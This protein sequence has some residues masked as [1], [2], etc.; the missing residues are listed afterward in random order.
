MSSIDQRIVQ[1]QFDNKGFEGG[2]RTTLNSLKTLQ[3]SLKM[4]NATTGLAEV[5]KGIKSVGTGGLS[6]LA[7]G[8]DTVA[9][10]FS[11]MSVVAISALANI[12]N[13]AVNAGKN[14]VKS[15]TIEPIT[16]G[17]SEYETKI[18]AIQTILTNTAHQGTSL[19]QVTAAL[20]ELNLYA[21]KTIYNFAEMTKN[22]GTFT[23]AG[24]DL[25]TAVMSIKGIA[26]LAAGSGSTPQQASTAM[27]QLSQ[28]L[29]AGK[30]SLMDWNSVVNAGMGGKLFQD[31]LIDTAKGMGKVV[32]AG[33]P[34]R[35]TLQDGWLTSDVLTKTLQKFADDPSL[36]QAATQVKTLSGLMDTMKESVQSGW[37]QSMEMIFGNKDQAAELFTGISEGFNS[38]IEPSTEA[39]NAMLKFW[40]ENGGRDDVIKGFTNIVQSVGKG[41]GSIKDAFGEVFP[42][43]T[44]KKLV[45]M[46]KGFK[47][48]TEKFKMSDKTAGM[49][50]DTFK[51]VFSV[52]DI[53]IQAVKG[54]V[55][56][57]IPFGGV[58]KGLGSLLLTTT[59]S[60]GKFFTSIGKG[61]KSSEIFDKITSGVEKGVGGITDFLSGA[62]KGIEGFFKAISSLNF[63]PLLDGFSKI[64]SGLGSG[65]GD[66]F[67]GLGKQ[68][69]KIDFNKVIGMIGALAAGKGLLALKDITK[70]VK[71]AFD[72]LL[73]IPGSIAGILDGVRESLEA[74]QANLNAGTLLKLAAS[75]GILA[76]SLGLIASLDAAGLE[77]A[78]TGVTVLM[79]EL[80]ASL[81]ILLKIAAGNKFKGF[82]AMSTAMVAFSVA[83]L[84]LSAA[85]K[86]IAELDIQQLAI[87]LAGLAGTMGL[88]L[89]ATK[90]LST[91]SK[92]LIKTSVGML[93]LAGAIAA[94]A[95]AVKMFGQIDPGVLVQGL[96]SVGALLAG[97]AVFLKVTDFSGMSISS[98]VGILILAAALNVLAVAVDSLGGMDTGAMIQGLA[99]VGAVLAE[100]AIF[101]KFAG[102]GPGLIATGVGLVAVGVA[103]NIVSAAIS[104]MG[105]MSLETIGKG[106]LAMAGSLAIMGA[107]VAL[108][109]AGSLIGTAVG[110]GLM[111]GALLILSMALQ[112]MGGM[113]WEEIGKS[114]VTL[115]GSLTILAVAMAFMT[116]GLPG[117]AAMLVMS[118][119]LMLFVPQ[120]IALS[121]LSLAQVGIGLL[122]LAGAFAVLGIA[123]LLLTPVVPVLLGLA[124]AIAILG[125]GAMAAGI[126]ITMFATGLATLVAVG[127]A[128]GMALVEV[129]RQLIN[130]LPEF[131]GKLAEAFVSFV[132]AIGEAVPQMITAVGQM[133]SGILTAFTE[134]LPQI[135]DAALALIE[136]LCTVIGQA[137]PKLVKIGVDLILALLQGIA[138]NMGRLVKSGV[139]IIVN[140]I[141]GISA[142]VGR[143]IQ[144]GIG[145]V[146]S[147]ANGI[148]SNS[149]AATAA[150]LNLISACVGAITGA[151]GQFLSKG[152]EAVGKF[153][154]G[155]MSGIGRALSTGRQIATNAVNGIRSGIGQM[156]SIGSQ[157]ISGL[158]SGIK[159]MAGRV[160]SAAKGVVQGAI[161]GAKSLLGIHSPSRVF[162]GIGKFTILGFAKGM[163]DNLVIAAD[164]TRDVARAAIDNMKN[165]LSKVA[166]ILNG[167]I[168]VTPTITPV[169]D[170]SK[171]EKGAKTLRQ[172]VDEKGGLKLDPKVSGGLSKSIGGVQNGNDNSDIV[173]ELKNLKKEISNV[174][175]T[176]YQVNGVTYDDGSNVSTAVEDLVH[177]A[178]IERRK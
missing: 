142:N 15:L 66:M 84:I 139:D 158:I 165:P 24:I 37:A 109:P 59:S 88:M 77:R 64:T 7:S 174:G 126:G 125:L 73:E 49:I 130:L 18:N 22:I 94:M 168:D 169:M 151:I 52:F 45:E 63:A 36:T 161:D 153:V 32:D 56:A 102:G 176:T 115:A 148:R 2:V 167:K 160:V 82:F 1:M 35:E 135:G 41:L 23:A 171:I 118:A 116:T 57:F 110:I 29:A 16:T 170:L 62:T 48:L 58:F 145:L 107:A 12:T 140:F 175:G 122:A 10:K 164:A 53:G 79:I 93:I 172:L 128:G 44:G 19:K 98:S 25:D 54:V 78:L 67:A 86:N 47:D 11:A 3:E 159:S 146:N 71:G 13:S 6:G 117:A 89:A 27:Y 8:V 69:G 85:L 144:A 50:K 4:K 68:I 114:L 152:T 134:A 20:D 106:L 124:G 156:T 147:L 163:K 61:L 154:S 30:V 177:A 162:A 76:L 133:I 132:V 105:S 26:N 60:I 34:F 119:A 97:L 40:N 150:V 55:K 131:G 121:Q 95:G 108:I 136:T 70:S 21:D 123:G 87:G 101:S 38:I 43:M 104:S 83:I 178:K 17:F 90:L 112:S 127:A 113:S 72:S 129:L 65:L 103:L 39:R 120:L 81:A 9:S 100:L 111:S 80:I 5:D 28:A 99:G 149:P 75:I 14:L 51:G 91:S 157:M 143:I 173:D 33:K 138:S 141:N 31:A 155:L 74:Y 42:P 46:S 96:L 137:V 92:G 166:K